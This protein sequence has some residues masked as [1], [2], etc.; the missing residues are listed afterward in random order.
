MF[1]PLGP[2]MSSFLTFEG[3][4]FFLLGKRVSS[5]IHELTYNLESGLKSWPVC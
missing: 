2:N 5:C 1:F 3:H 4:E